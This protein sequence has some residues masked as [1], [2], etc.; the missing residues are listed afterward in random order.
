MPHTSETARLSGATTLPGNHQLLRLH[1]PQL[2]QRLAAGEQLSVEGVVLPLMRC[3]RTQQWGEVLSA[4]PLP[5]EQ[6]STLHCEVVGE[7]FQL[8]SAPITALLLAE[9][10][11]LAPITFLADTLRKERRHSLLVLLGFNNEIPFRPAPSRIMVGN[12][13]A[14]VIAT[15]PLFEDWQLPCRIAHADEPPGCFG[16]DVI[17]LARHWLGRQRG[18]A[19]VLYCSGGPEMGEAAASLARELGLTRQAIVVES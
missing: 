17:T 11:G 5:W 4:A 12:L 15:M 13:P 14:G 3:H 1:L 9:G 6:G 2:S 16:G 7:P 10:L 8:P 18:A 19:P